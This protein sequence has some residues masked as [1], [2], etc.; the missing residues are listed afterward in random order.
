MWIRNKFTSK[1]LNKLIILYVLLIYSFFKMSENHED[2]IKSYA[3]I[4]QE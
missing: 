1:S 3:E 4:K 2:E